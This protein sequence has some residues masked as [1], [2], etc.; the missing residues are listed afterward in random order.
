MK[1]DVFLTKMENKNL[2]RQEVDVLNYCCVGIIY[3]HLPTGF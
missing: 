3:N 1:K 2:P